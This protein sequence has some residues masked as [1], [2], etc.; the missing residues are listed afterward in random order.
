MDWAASLL[1]GLGLF[2]LG[3]KALS[4]QLVAL[5]GLRL[6]GAMAKGAARPLS[7][8]LVGLL[9]GGVTQSGN[10]VTFIAA[11]LR[12]AGLLATARMLPLLAWANVG[13]AGLVLVASFD[14]RF[15]ALWLLALCGA[16]TYFGLDGSGR[17]RPLLGAVTGLGLMLLGLALVKAGAEPL[18]GME[19]VQGLLAWGAR[20]FLWLFLLG[21]LV[22]LVA[23]SSSTVAILLIMLQAAGLI[24]FEQAAAGICGAGLGS[25]LS[26]RLLGAR[27][28]GSARQA[29]LAQAG[30]RGA[31]ALLVL[32]LV[33]LEQ[34]GLSPLLLGVLRGLAEGPAMQL[35][36]L[37]LAQQ[38][39]VALLAA[40]L[41]RPLAA[42]LARLAPEA[43]AE[44]DGRP[45][46]LFEQ[47]L[48]EPAS[49]L[50]LL[51]AEQA[52]L[53]ERLPALLDPLREEGAGRAAPT[54]GSA[55]LEAA[56]G[57]FLAALLA[58]ELPPPVLAEAVR[59][60]ARLGHL[61]ALREALEEFLA[62]ARP[63]REGALGERI[64]AMAEALHLLLEELRE[65]DG[66]E[67]AAWLAEL[68]ADR[69][70]MMQRLRRALAEVAR[71]EAFRLTG[72]FER[73]VWLI[74]RLA[75]L[76]GERAV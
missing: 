49:A 29:V 60:Q 64:A 67:A 28:G 15:A 36:L 43:E 63:L 76:E 31:G 2:F 11:S 44:A 25:A 54:A 1:G 6:R 9:L 62:T 21:A 24:G 48:E 34:A 12:S 23:Q 14:L 16:L 5:A 10:A 46:Y 20:G 13:T 22:T 41:H 40:P 27:L 65:L 71:E 52:R 58:R 45:R 56:I 74:R 42:L 75:L 53:V 33:W 50:P 39:L 26:V 35:A 4:A 72:V 19:A 51:R 55:A 37:F 69:G 73:A 3:V 8:A 18:R 32:V 61:A 7:A 57:R 38:L 66:P 70:E 47:A 68:A 17:M 30:L 59:L